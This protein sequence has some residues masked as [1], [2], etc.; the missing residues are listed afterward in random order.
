VVLLAPRW[1]VWDGV[2]VSSPPLLVLWD[3]DRTLVDAHGVSR[4][5][6]SRALE[7]VIGRPPGL[8]AD[9]A[10]RTDRSIFTESASENCARGV[11]TGRPGM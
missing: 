4:E 3:I 10:G 5:I 6:V 7:L 11:T 9:M 8:L 2:G 1:V